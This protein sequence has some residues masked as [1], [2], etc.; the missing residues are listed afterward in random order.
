MPLDP[1]VKAFL[2]Q[3]EA[4]SPPPFEALTPKEARSAVVVEAMTL[5]PP[6][7]LVAVHD[8]NVPGPGGD[9]PVR[10]YVPDEKRPLPVFV[11]FHGGGCVVGDIPT[12]DTICSSV[13]NAAGCLVVSV[14]YRLAPE[15]KYPAA[16]EDAFAATE[17]VREHAEP[18]GGD[19][20]RV[21]V[22]GD[23]AG[24]NLAAVVSLMAR[25]R[26][27][28]LPALQVL[29]YPITDYNFD[30]PSYSENADG[31]LLTRQTM[32]WFWE[33]YLPDEEAG[34]E[35]YASPLRA[36][37]LSGLPPAL[38]I[39]AQYDPLRDEGEAYAGRLREAGVPVDLTRYD[40]MI[41][42]FFR[43]TAQFDKAKTALEE[44]AG[45]LRRAFEAA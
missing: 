10:I 8:R 38:V 24:G 27:A 13:A 42:A 21:A 4:A 30:T 6:E 12:H 18:I 22:G 40:G 36:E 43:K 16:A 44:V 20:R 35:P 15:H 1:Q 26:R 31:Y 2:D 32:K 34:R 9:V 19:P 11:Y 41:H 7:P 37:N 23:S 45:A 5:G 17:W 39:T 14:G 33:H 25:D 29:V 3:R 28:P